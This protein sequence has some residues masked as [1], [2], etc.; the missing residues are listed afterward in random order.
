MNACGAQ[1]DA[2]IIRDDEIGTGKYGPLGWTQGR[3]ECKP[4]AVIKEFMGLGKAPR[5]N[6]GRNP[7][8][9]VDPAEEQGDTRKLRARD[10]FL[11]LPLIG[12]LGLGGK[13]TSYPEETIVGDY[14]GM[15][16]DKGLPTTDDKGVI[17]LVYRQVCPCMRSIIF[18]I[19]S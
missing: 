19:T 10:S 5:Y 14:A 4:D 16:K 11:N 1:A 6:G 12:F 2:S 17:E 13:R 15:G 3:G 9:P 8:G 18:S 7:T